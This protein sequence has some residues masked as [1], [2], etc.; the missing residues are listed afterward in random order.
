MTLVRM[1][2]DDVLARW[3]PGSHDTADDPG[4]A[5]LA[6]TWAH[7]FYDLLNNPEQRDRT[8]AVRLRV[9]EEGIGFV[10]GVTPIQL[11]NDGRVWDGHHRLCVARE[12]GIEHVLVQVD[13]EET[14][15]G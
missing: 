9:V 7:E 10:D 15:H 6:W 3:R 1:A 12:L 5:N 14:S 4:G 2:V 11:G 13:N 8:A